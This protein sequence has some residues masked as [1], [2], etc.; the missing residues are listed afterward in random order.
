VKLI[1]QPLDIT[2]F[3][4]DILKQMSV[5]QGSYRFLHYELTLVP[6]RG[7]EEYSVRVFDENE[8]V[9]FWIATNLKFDQSLLAVLRFI[10]DESIKILFSKRD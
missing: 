2:R 8:C 6:E 3:N 1:N 7:E 4:Y 9:V 10:E 5:V